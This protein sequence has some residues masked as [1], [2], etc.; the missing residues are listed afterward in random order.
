[1]NRR[2]SSPSPEDTLARAEAA[3]R[4]TPVPPG[5]PE[6]IDARTLAAL[7]AGTLAP[8]RPLL[9]RWRGARPALRLTAALLLLA[10]GL[11]YLGG[12]TR[13]GPSLV[14]ARVAQRFRAHTLA[15]QMTAQSPQF[16]QTVTMQVFLTE[17]GLAR[18][19]GPLGQITV[20][21]SEQ[22]QSKI[23]SLVP[24]TKTAVL[25][26]QKGPKQPSKQADPMEMVQQLRELAEKNA[27]PAGRRQF[28][29]V[30]AQGFRVQE[31]NTEWLI[32]A[33]PKTRLPLQVEFTWP[34]GT[35]GTMSEFRFNPK[36]DDALFSLEVPEGYKLQPVELENLTPEEHLVRML[37]YCAETSAGQ[38]PK[39]LDDTVALMMR[40]AK[41]KDRPE[42]ESMRLAASIVRAGMFV[43]SL[44]G[45]YGYRPDGT[46]LG[47]SNKILFWYRPAAATKYRALYGDLHWA[48]LTTDQ[49]P[50]VPKP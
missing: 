43:T 3:L 24:I 50:E 19:E 36:L 37:R 44:K 25:L 1:M 38:F 6:T 32:W 47:D 45:A 31:G 22:N 11:V 2:F 15:Y 17:P 34:D 39:R 9:F 13:V 21:N 4:Q 10:G 40:R 33:D 28:G 27:E 49:L 41:S 26:V 30:E 23:L 5:P 16:K 8:R 20:C 7:R 29:D 42:P 46:K 12:M 35:R 14:F 18:I 48:D